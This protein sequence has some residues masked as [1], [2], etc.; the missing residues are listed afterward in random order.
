MIILTTIAIKLSIA[1]YLKESFKKIKLNI[2]IYY[3]KDYFNI[4]K[5]ID[6]LICL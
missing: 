3:M 6:Y 2:I 4:S 5:K 1:C